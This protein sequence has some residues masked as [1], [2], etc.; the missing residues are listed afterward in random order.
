MRKLLLISILIIVPL[1]IFVVL[2]PLETATGAPAKEIT[3]AG[4]PWYHEDWHYRRPVTITNPCSTA[5]TDYQAQITLDSSFDFNNA[6][7]DASDLL[8]TAS[9]GTTLIPFWGE[10]WD[11]VGQ[12]ASIWVSVPSLPITGTSVMLYY[13]NADPIIDSPPIGPW[14]KAVNNP[15]VPIGGPAGGNQLLAENIV[16]DSVT[17]RYWMTFANYNTSSVGL[18]WSNDPGDPTSWNWFGDVISQANAPHILEYNGTWYIFYADRT[19]PNPWP[20]SVA[21][22]PQISGTYT[23]TGTVLYPGAAGSWEDYR[24]DEPYVFQRNDGQWILMYMGD[25]GSTT[26]QVG[27]AQADDI[28]GPYTKFAGNPAIPFGPPGS[29]DAGT[30]ADPWVVEFNGTYYIGYTVSPTK[31]RP[32]RTAYVTTTDWMTFTKYGIILDIG[33]NGAWDDYSAFRGAVTLFDDTY[34]FTYTGNDGSIYR[35]GIATQTVSMPVALSYGESVFPFF[36][37]FNDGVFD[38]TKW[39]FGN[40]DTD[41]VDESGGYLTLVDDG[42]Y[43]KIFGNMSVGMEHLVES[44]GRHP[45]AGNLNVAAEIGFGNSGWS[46]IVRILDYYISV[47]PSYNWQRSSSSGGTT[48]YIPMAQT[49]DTNWHTFRVY[50][51]TGDPDNFAGFQIDDNPAETHTAYVPTINLPAW[52]MSYGSGNQFILDWIR[53][54]Q[55]CGA[56]A[57]AT[58]RG[59]SDIQETQE[60]TTTGRL[61]FN[62]VTT[63]VTVTTQGTLSD[64]QM[65]LYQHDHP[66]ATTPIQTGRYWEI[67]PTG[68]GYTLDLTLPLQNPDSLDKNCRHAGVGQVWDCAMSSFNLIAGTITRNGITQLSDWAVGDDVSPTSLVLETFTASTINHSVPTLLLVLVVVSLGCIP[69]IF[70]YRRWKYSS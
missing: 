48:N 30:V 64:L 49:V 40:G 43:V 9:D 55:Y 66:D 11:S 19:V 63:T 69:V 51:L 1:S 17:G 62:W 2:F 24:V 31:T 28:L 44:Y 36:D 27:Y 60:V 12:D 18:V 42:T 16:Y 50:R 25:A 53:I 34:Y 6:L 4:T 57:T 7:S 33:P 70:L 3:Q 22:S 32:W 67:N 37:D 38:T 68:S 5:Q 56:D 13:G 14:T 45:Q 26:E 41:N 23:Y 20:I 58:V 47:P 59:Y 39:N 46:D 29:I 21:T 52:L 61:D 8:V 10:S 65:V 15:I 35:M 54:R